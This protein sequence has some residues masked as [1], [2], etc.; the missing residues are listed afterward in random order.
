MS[1]ARSI[2]QVSRGFTLVELMIVVAIIGVLGAVALPAFSRYV[3]KSRTAEAAAHLNKMWQSSVAYFEGDQGAG[4]LAKQFPDTDGIIGNND[5]CSATSAR[6]PGN[7]TRF[8]NPTWQALNFFIPD[9]HNYYPTYTSAGRN[10]TSEFLAGATGDLDCDDVRS[11]FR[12]HGTVNGSGEIVGEI[13]G[14][15]APIIMNELE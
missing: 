15:T 8:S 7:D 6:C 13:S 5:C 12:R 3:K 11:T 10:E 14:S 9:P 1:S 4:T 2:R